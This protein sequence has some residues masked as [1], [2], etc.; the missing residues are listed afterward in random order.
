[1]NNN[2]SSTLSDLQGLRLMR[3]FLR[4]P[5]ASRRNEIVE[6][7]ERLAPTLPAQTAAEV[8]TDPLA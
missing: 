4:I 5:D 1:M 7:A 2:S 8:P 6:M 3:A